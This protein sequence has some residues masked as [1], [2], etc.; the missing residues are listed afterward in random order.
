MCSIIIVIPMFMVHF[1][2]FREVYFKI[3][4]T[5]RKTLQGNLVRKFLNYDESSRA[6]LGPSDLI[7]E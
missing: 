4:G 7:M 3:G 6:Q 2:E 1:L 5:S